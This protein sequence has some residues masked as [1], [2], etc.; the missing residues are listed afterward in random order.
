MNVF[1]LLLVGAVPLMGYLCARFFGAHFGLSGQIVGFVVGCLLMVFL[2]YLL[3]RLMRASRRGA[4]KQ[5][6]ETLERNICETVQEWCGS[7]PTDTC[8][9]EIRQSAGVTPLIFV[10]PCR[11]ETCRVV[12][13]P[14]P[15]SLRLFIGRD[16]YSESIRVPSRAD[17]EVIRALIVPYLDAARNSNVRVAEGA[18]TTEIAL[19]LATEI[20]RKRI[21]TIASFDFC[22][23]LDPRNIRKRIVRFPYQP[24]DD[25]A[26]RVPPEHWP[27]GSHDTRTVQ[28]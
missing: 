24:W 6:D 20:R 15:D 1:E 9:V 25:E 3:G 10:E 28:K 19:L 26:Q 16:L 12:F 17:K 14:F 23:L 2:Y 5:R 27:D 22:R 4:E 18:F 21:A 7:L 13:S 8:S 11:P